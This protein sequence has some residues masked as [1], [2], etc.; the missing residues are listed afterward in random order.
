MEEFKVTTLLPGLLQIENSVGNCASLVLGEKRALLFDTMCGIGDLKG[1]VES[2]TSLPLTVVCSHG[3]FDHMGGNHQFERVYMNRADWVIAEKTLPYLEVIQKN[4]GKDLSG[5]RRSFTMTECLADYGEGEVFDLGG[6]TAHAVSLRGH[7]EGSMGLMIPQL[8]TLLVG[9]ATSPTMC[10]FFPDSL[11]IPEY[12]Q[13]LQ[14][15]MGMDFDYFVQGHYSRLFPKEILGKFWEC[16][17]LPGKK[18]GLEYINTHIPDY[19]GKLY[20]LELRNREIDSMICL[21]DK[22]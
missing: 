15:M 4:M 10:L 18:R 13:T 7:T 11:G 6:L 8:R 1:F 17:L 22:E 16:T 19:K 12:Q 9:D 3:H 2:L 21:I 20:M 14:K 5:A